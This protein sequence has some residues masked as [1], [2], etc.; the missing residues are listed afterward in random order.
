MG[1]EVKLKRTHDARRSRCTNDDV[2]E[3]FAIYLGRQADTRP[4][5]NALHEK[6]RWHR[7]ASDVL[8]ATATATTQAML[9]SFH[10]HCR[11]E[12]NKKVSELSRIRTTISHR[13][14]K[15]LDWDFEL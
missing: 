10:L 12:D 4:Y 14:V 8:G 6:Y 9:G 5:L 2:L 15:F 3:I 1:P 7:P 11:S 13:R